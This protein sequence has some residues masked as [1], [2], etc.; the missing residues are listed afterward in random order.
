[1]IAADPQVDEYLEDKPEIKK[2]GDEMTRKQ[3]WGL[4][5]D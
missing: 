5:K 3:E 4:L 1:M 2:F